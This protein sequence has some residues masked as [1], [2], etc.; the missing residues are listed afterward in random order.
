MRYI[1]YNYSSFVYSRVSF[2]RHFNRHLENCINWP[3]T[4]Y[5]LLT[6]IRKYITFEA[7]T[8]IYKSTILPI[9]EYRDI[10][11]T[12][13]PRHRENRENYNKN[14]LSGKYCQNTGKTQGI[15][16]AQVV[17]SLILKVKDTAIFAVKISIQKTNMNIVN[18]R[19]VNIR[20]H[21]AILLQN[22]LLV[23][24]LKVK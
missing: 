6:K 2:N 8:Q 13:Y 15:L 19:L 17:N 23:K 14:S 21:D 11:Y 12:G 10:S 18:S 9:L 22:D 7:A 1:A 16:F 3:L 4:K 5:V 20:A 24:K